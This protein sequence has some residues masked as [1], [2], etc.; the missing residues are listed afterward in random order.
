MNRAIVLSVEIL[1]VSIYLQDKLWPEIFPTR[2]ILEVVG[3]GLEERLLT[4]RAKSMRYYTLE[5]RLQQANV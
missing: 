2:H 3:I 4:R 1:I 5:L